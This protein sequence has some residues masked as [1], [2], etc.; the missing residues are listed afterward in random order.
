MFARNKVPV[1]ITILPGSDRN[2]LLKRIQLFDV[3]TTTVINQVSIHTLSL[4][5]GALNEN[6]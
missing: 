6:N 4:S 1:N 3:H 2:S 5:E